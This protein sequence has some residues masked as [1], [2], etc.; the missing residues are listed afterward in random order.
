MKMMKAGLLAIMVVSMVMFTSS[1]IYAG[2]KKADKSEMC[3]DGK[4]IMVS[5]NAIKAHLAHGDPDV[6]VKEGN[7]CR[8]YV[9]E[10]S[11]PEPVV[12]EPTPSPT[13]DFSW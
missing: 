1:S 2:G 11:E 6:F 5:G 9:A 13:F 12:P 8:E 7:S 4:V 3:H 10:Q